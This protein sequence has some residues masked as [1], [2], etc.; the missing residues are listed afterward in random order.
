[1]SKPIVAIIGR[2]NVGKS[3]LFNKLV[4]KKIS[5][6]DN[7]PGVTRDRIYADTDWL[8]HNFTLID[9][10]GLESYFSSSFSRFIF[11]Q[12]QIAID[13]SDLILFIIDG[14]EGITTLDQEIAQILRKSHRKVL[15]VANK[16]DDFARDKNKIYEFY[17]LGFGEPILVSA[18]QSLGLGDLLDEI[19][20]SFDNI[21]SKNLNQNENDSIIKVA[22]IGRPNVGKSSIV[23]KILGQQR[24]IVSDISGTTRD[25]IDSFYKKDGQDYI[26]IDTAGIRKK[27]KIKESL[28]YYSIVRAIGAV[29]RS[30][31][32]ILILNA[33]DGITEQDI[34]I[35]GIAHENGKP[36]IIAVNKWDKIDKDN[37]TIN[38][39][40][41]EIKYRL[42]YMQYALKIFVSALTGQRITKIFDMINIAW[43]NTNLRIK[44]GILNEL[45]LET[46]A[47]NSPAVHKGRQLKIY[48]ATQA[49]VCPPTFV[50]FVND[51]SLLHFTYRRYLENQIRNSFGFAGTPIRFVVRNKSD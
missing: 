16:I 50:L 15:L 44:T 49:S 36:V 6:T 24:S 37:K 38:K 9:T 35:A 51:K 33:E 32:C 19:I 46:L 27:N 40:S 12:A 39:F 1:M 48:Y 26:F 18:E 42:S 41:D 22:I 7:T 28:E 34:K 10:G 31:V 30:N 45:L 20:K 21:S 13:T 5:I 2:P 17:S 8:D 4:G 23:N 29:E 47:M 3:T 14:R 43:A 25:A 11:E